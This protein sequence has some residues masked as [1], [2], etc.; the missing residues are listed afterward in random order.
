MTARLANT[1][2]LDF[3]V[4]WRNKFYH[5]SLALAVL[6][7]FGLSQLIGTAFELGAMLPVFYL[8][9]I[10]GTT[11][12]FVAGQIIFE[13]DD[14]TLDALTV[15]PLRTAE[16]M[17]SK[18]ISLTFLSTLEST[19][20]FVGAY[21]LRFGI[22]DVN[23]ILLYTGLIMM[24]IMLTLIGFIM[25]VRYKSITDFLFPVLGLLF[26]LQL[27]M[28]HF[29]GLVVSDLWYAFPTM[30]MTLLMAGAFRDLEAWQ[31]IYGL[32][33]SVILI[34][35]LHRWAMSAFY[36]FIILQRS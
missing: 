26:V 7:A 24:G 2:K 14:N 17:N 11:L 9:A 30:P 29:N 28:L 13:R 5:I 19:I 22:A 31:V 10:G 4:H 35:V 6:I 1:I 34:V 12:M 16:Y 32:G 18:I 15:S 23:L 21:V 33:Y 20:V 36:K 27:P 25:V 3:T 8:L